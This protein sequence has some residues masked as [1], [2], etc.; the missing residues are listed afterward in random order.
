MKISIIVSVYNRL[1]C[2]YNLLNALRVQTYE[3]F[4]VLIADDGSK[5]DLTSAIQKILPDLSFPVTHVFQEDIGFRLSRSRNNAARAASGDYYLF[6]DQDVLMDRDFLTECRRAI[7]EHC[8]LKFKALYLD[9]SRSKVFQKEA[10]QNPEIPVYE[11]IERQVTRIEKLLCMKSRWKDNLFNIAWRLGLRKK[12]MKLRGLAIGISKE[13]YMAINGF[14]EAYIGWGFEDDD[15]CNRMYAYG[16][17]G[18][19]VKLGSPLVHV[20]HKA[21]DTR[22]ASPNSA[23]YFEREKLIFENN[24]YRCEYGFD[25]TFGQDAVSYSELR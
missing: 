8:F 21:A 25:K 15:I 23:Y 16:L 6:L 14:D 18:V 5:E 7:H 24:V 11:V 1:H 13:D 4:E 22:E 12:G 2:L 9:E 10:E 20:W 3:D 19:H 17:K